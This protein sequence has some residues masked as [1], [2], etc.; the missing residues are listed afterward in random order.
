MQSFHVLEIKG[1]KMP[2]YLFFR[3]EIEIAAYDEVSDLTY[4]KCGC[5]VLAK[6][7]ARK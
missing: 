5:T 7:G 6:I 2:I 1:G 4:V 3:S